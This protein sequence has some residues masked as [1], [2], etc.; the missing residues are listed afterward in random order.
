V[1]KPPN[2]VSS[3]VLLAL[4]PLVV[5]CGEPEI[6]REDER[7]HGRIPAACVRSGEP[8]TVWPKAEASFRSKT[9]DAPHVGCSCDPLPEWDKTCSTGVHETTYSGP[10]GYQIA[11]VRCDR[12]SVRIVRDGEVEG[13]EARSESPV[14]TATLTIDLEV[15]GDDG[16]TEGEVTVSNVL[17][18]SADGICAEGL[19]NPRSE[20]SG[21]CQ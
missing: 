11:D 14:G 21:G 18:W 13:V 8:V 16:E 12:C 1:I 9:C 17:H 19:D 20:E 10:R 3:L 4:L 7:L 5:A 2:L 6:D 15:L